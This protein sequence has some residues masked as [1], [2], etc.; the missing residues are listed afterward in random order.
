MI[1]TDCYLDLKR[2]VIN[3]GFES[4][5][6]WADGLQLC[7]SAD[8][9]ACETCWVIINGGMKEQ[10]ARVIWNRVR[11]RLMAGEGVGDSFKHDGKAKAIDFV[12]SNRPRLY[13]E[14]LGHRE[15]GRLQFLA[16]LPWIGPITKYHLARN[17]G[18]DVCKPDRHLVRLAAP[19]TPDEMCLRLSEETGDRIGVVDCVIWRAANLG[20][21]YPGSG[22]H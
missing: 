18:L 3:A 2:D 13:Q 11:P 16:T 15:E 6:D 4:E 8:W 21:A 1:T 7:N 10:V 22:K 9:F 12:W 5:I 17:L 20:I 19:E 14:W